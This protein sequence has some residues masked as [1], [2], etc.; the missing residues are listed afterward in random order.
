MYKRR[1]LLACAIILEVLGLRAEDFC[2][3]SPDS[4]L[5]AIIH[6]VDGKLTYNVARD[7]RSIVSESPLGL[8]LSNSD[9]TVGLELVSTE[10]TQVD[11]YYQLPVGKRRD[12]H[13]HCNI[14][15]VHTVKDT[16]Q[17]TIQFRVYN[18]G[19]AFRYIIPKYGGH[20]SAT[21]TGENSRICVSN[22]SNCTACRFL[23]NPGGNDP[24]YAY[25]GL[26]DK[27]TNWANLAST[28]DAR[29]NTPTLVYN[30]KDYLLLSEADNRS[31]FCTSLLKA[32]E[33]KGEF[34]YS[35]TGT[36]KDYATEKNQRMV[37]SLPASTPWR[38]AV[39]G[40]IKTIF[41]TTM[42]ENLCPATAINTDWIRPGV[43][44]WYW[45]GS[46]GNKNDIQN[47]YGGL[48]EGEQA[49]ADLSAEMGWP[50][51][52]IDGGWNASWIP[53]L[54][55]HASDNGV[56]CLLWQTAKLN[57]SQ[58]FSN[59]NME[60]TLK[61]W[62]NWGIKGV[63][64]DF[65]EDDSKETMTRMENLLKTAAKLEML[66]NFHGCTRPSGLRRTYPNLMTQ[67]AVL[68]GEQNFWAPKRI[69]TQHHLNLI[70]TRN[71]VGGMDYTPGDFA[72]WRGSILTSLSMGQRMALLTAFESSIVH[73]A[74]CPENLQYF[75]GRDIMKR[76]PTTWDESILL[77]GNPTSFATIARRKGEDWWLS[78]ISINERTFRQKL[79]FLKDGQKYTA[80]IYRDG[81][82]RSELK[83]DKKEVTS[84][85]ILSFKEL[86][87]GGFLVQI[88]PDSNLDCP[89][90]R[91]TYE[92]EATS[93]TITGK[94]T[95]ETFSNLHASAGGFVGNMGMGSKIQF[96]NVV[97][98]RTGQYL[99]TIYYITVDSRPSKLLINGEL[100]GDSIHFQGNSDCMNSWNPD[101]M[102]WKMIP[103]TLREGTNTITLQT[104]NNLWAPNFDRITIHKLLTEEET[105]IIAIPQDEHNKQG[106]SFDLSGRIITSTSKAPR[107]YIR[108]GKKV[109]R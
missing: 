81:T 14:L 35:W 9:M 107:L 93:N 6:L 108:N 91:T 18:D 69:T 37:C 80:Y 71:V 32:E 7:E 104:Y 102:G 29:Y 38:M 23:G 26:Y 1:L 77:E 64:V 105:P 58:D 27:Y 56:E 31:I 54:V 89:Q 106:L 75:L 98:D 5:T 79:S 44:G 20:S 53:S 103:I 86:S 22:F 47:E 66:V 101:G 15:S 83:F 59:A 45:G 24:N 55:N 16:W 60:T 70:F 61:K 25:E 72:T 2:V 4:H 57:T 34:S 51:Y 99:L 39:C 92:A 84:G 73:I 96:D 36:T 43:A 95:R 97:A 94:A 8:K 100:V 87:E 90:E 88:S 82:C 30:G 62:K 65:F 13:D 40:D 74:E 21:L 48:L 3:T 41:E 78:G 67:E 11:D 52:L 42:A 49:H 17:Q 109:L 10:T 85:D 76:L 50:Y 68:G 28:G 19:F 63:K 46:D 12:Y 33:T